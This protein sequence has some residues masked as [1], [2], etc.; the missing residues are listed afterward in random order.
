M[1]LGLG[2]GLGLAH[3]AYATAEDDIGLGLG[4]AHEAYATAEDDIGAEDLARERAE[5]LGGGRRAERGP[6]DAK[7]RHEREVW[8]DNEHQTK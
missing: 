8:Q 6:A 4:L 3:E 1:G 2:L 7:A 5:Q